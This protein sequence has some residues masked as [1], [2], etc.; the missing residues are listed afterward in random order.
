MSAASGDRQ[1][2]SENWT[3]DCDVFKPLSCHQSRGTCGRVKLAWLVVVS[4]DPLGVEH[5]AR[6]SYQL[7]EANAGP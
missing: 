7:P 4:L 6:D 2:G 5:V 1:T 3:S